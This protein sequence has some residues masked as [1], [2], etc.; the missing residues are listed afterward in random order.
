MGMQLLIIAIEGYID[1]CFCT[2]LNLNAFFR[3]RDFGDFLEFF[4]SGCDVLS[5]FVT[6]TCFGI[7]IA[8]PIF[9][10][11]TLVRNKENLSR[12]DLKKRYGHFYIGLHTTE[13]N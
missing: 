13:T 12:K 3:A 1:I 11:V 5:S 4:S 9:I 7:I 6:L 8:L 2:F 10:L